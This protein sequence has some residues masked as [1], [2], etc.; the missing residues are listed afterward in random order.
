VSRICDGYFEKMVGEIGGGKI[1]IRKKRKGKN[2]S[3]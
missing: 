2:Y 3:S 1:E